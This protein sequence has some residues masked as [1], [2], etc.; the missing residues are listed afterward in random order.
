[1]VT[2]YELCYE[3]NR[4]RLVTDVW[5]D[6]KWDTRLCVVFPQQSLVL[7]NVYSCFYNFVE[8]I[9]WNDFCYLDVK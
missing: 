7:Q 8:N 2:S 5:E 9:D 4:K 1:M 6:S 3:G